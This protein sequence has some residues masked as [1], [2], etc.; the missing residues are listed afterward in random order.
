MNT[1]NYTQK[2]LEAVQAAQSLATEYGNQQIEQSHLLLALLTAENGLVPQLLAN[3]GLTVPSF[4]AAVKAQVEKLPKVSGPGREMGK[5]Y[6]S[7]G[8]DR[9]LNTAEE[10]A[11]QMKDEYV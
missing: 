7:Q 2:T 10:T 5:I 11:R 6:V 8:V 4:A 1:Q 9:A 3:M